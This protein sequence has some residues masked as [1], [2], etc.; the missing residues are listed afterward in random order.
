[1]LYI[2]AMDHARKLIFSSYPHLPPIN[3]MFQYPYA[4]WIL[5]SVAEV[6]IF[7]HGCYISALKHV[8]M[9]ILSSQVLLACTN[10]I[11]KYVYPWVI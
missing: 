5:C 11:Y 8:R 6:I 4:G 1:M 9:L 3:K 10:P 7:E 2:S